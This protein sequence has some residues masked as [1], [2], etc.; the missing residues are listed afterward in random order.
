MVGRIRELG[1]SYELAYDD[2]PPVVKDM[3][4]KGKQDI[5]RL[6]VTDKESGLASY[7]ATIDETFVVFDAKEK[8]SLVVC[9][10]RETPIKKTGK[11]HKLRF[12]AVDNRSNVVKY[13]TD[14]IY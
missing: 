8:T 1:H 2:R 5:I 14:I 6:S 13:E 4:G 3:T 11:A 9:D 7:T 10:L 12:T